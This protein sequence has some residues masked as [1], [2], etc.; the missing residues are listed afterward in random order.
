MHL[1]DDDRGAAIQIGAVIL[2]GFLVL[3]V[4]AWQVGVVP[5]E[6]ARVEF[7][8]SQRV[9][10][11]MGDVR[12]AI[13]SAP[14]STA[15]PAVGVDLAP[16]YPPR[17]IFVNPGPPT[18]TIRTVGT[19]DAAVAVTVGNATTDGEAGD[20]WDGTPTRYDTG[21]LA[22][23][24]GY[25]VYTSAPDTIY[26]TSLL[27]NV[28][29]DGTVVALADQRVVDGT[30]I[31][32]VT[33]HGS[34]SRTTADTISLDL[35]ALSTTATPVAVTN[36]SGSN[37]TV[38]FASLR[39][40]DWWNETFAAAGELDEDGGHV[41]DVR[42]GSPARA[43]DFYNVTVEFEQG[44][45]YD[46]RLASVGVGAHGGPPATAYAVD[47]S[48]NGTGVQVGGT[49]QLVVEVRDRYN[50]PVSGATVTVDAGASDGSV[51]PTAATTDSDGQATFLYDATGASPGPATIV[52][53]ASDDAS[54]TDDELVTFEI[55]VVSAGGGGGG[56]GGGS[57]AYAT[58]WTDASNNPGLTC[59]GFDADGPTDCTLDASAVQDDTVTL[60]M[61]TEP[62]ADGADVQYAV[63]DTDVAKVSPA[64]G[65]T[66]GTGA[67]ST[68][69]TA[70]T[71]GPVKV[72]VSSGASGDTLILTVE[73]T[74]GGDSTPPTFDQL[75]V[76]TSEPGTGKGG[77]G[78]VTTVE[79][80]YQLS[81][82]VA[83]KNVTFEV[84]ESDGTPLDSTTITYTGPVTSES[85]TVTLDAGGEQDVT[86]R[87]LVTDEAG[88]FERCEITGVN[89]ENTFTKGNFTC[90]TG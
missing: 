89:G 46:L 62:T 56:G 70:K 73:N 29:R 38:S 54:P 49:R 13:V 19:G 84:L 48:G 40:P 11:D 52:L 42:A 10:D 75:D 51:D 28:E 79:F 83:L 69:L 43:G 18:G 36:T 14:G 78:Q 12:N 85:G 50:N 17:A 65:M 6:N 37:I 90:T 60:T 87:A 31:T 59:S 66:D 30:S 82:N 80:D 22:Y 57:G 76:N 25:N 47:V 7:D 27:Y 53:N 8:H 23:D 34:F 9:Q 35:A 3:A 21:A 16:S 71:N 68:T 81:D 77:S 64:A 41:T 32:L 2:F 58:Y 15:L 20:F 72:Y 88:N 63:N 55:E 5:Q 45:T 33:L 26:D 4:A 24:S 39:A 74:S 61:D 44:E 67:N 86:I 1:R